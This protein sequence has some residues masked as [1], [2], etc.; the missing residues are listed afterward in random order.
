MVKGHVTRGVMAMAN[1][2]AEMTISG[3]MG[4]PVGFALNSEPLG[5]S[6]RRW[7]AAHGARL[8]PALAGRA[9]TVTVGQLVAACA[10][11]PG[12]SRGTTVAEVF[13]RVRELRAAKENDE[14]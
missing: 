14:E 6:M 1:N 4:G 8:D 12:G 11:M 7:A 9:D 13:E 2:M 3:L 10:G 5:P